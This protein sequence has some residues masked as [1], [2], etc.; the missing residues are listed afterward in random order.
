MIDLLQLRRL[1]PAEQALLER[2]FRVHD[3][4]LPAAREAVLESP[5]CN[6]IHAVITGGA[7]QVSARLIA[8]LPAL[9]IIAVQGA[10]LDGVDL[11][12]ARSRGVKVVGPPEAM[13]D[14]V[15][16]LAMALV[17]D[18]VRRVGAGDRFVRRGGW[19]DG[20]APSLARSLRGQT[21]GILGLGRIGSA[22]ASRAEAFGLKIAYHN[23][24]PVAGVNHAY[25]P[26][27]P[28][29]AEA[30]DIL[31]LTAPA[32]RGAPP[33]VTR[34]ILDRLGADGVLINVSRGALVGE[35]ALIAPC[36][37]AVWA[38]RAW[39]SSPTS[40]ACPKPCWRSKR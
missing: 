19:R 8:A 40:P 13:T 2:R 32:R 24:S 36:K 25:Y 9:E 1:A 4:R 30:S 10:G 3:G 22:V 28:L 7:A 20:D 26:S 37:T 38:A 27:L 16:D 23:R 5:V 35:P 17:L 18:T 14:D 6:R 15:A 29:L 33:A 21:L 34:A 39:M 31:V 11:D 12:A